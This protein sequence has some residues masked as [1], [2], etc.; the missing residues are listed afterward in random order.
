VKVYQRYLE[1]WKE[2]TVENAKIPNH[3]RDD[4]VALVFRSS[5]ELLVLDRECAVKALCI[6]HHLGSY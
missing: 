3:M 5:T 6:T 4:G 2:V 1:V